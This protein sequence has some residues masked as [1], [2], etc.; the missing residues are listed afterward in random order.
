M[1]E[2]WN[3]FAEIVNTTADKHTPLATKRVCAESLPW[4][5]SEIRKM[6]WKR[7][8]HHK[9]AQKQKSTEGW[10]K[11][12]ELGNN[13]TCLIRNAKHDFYSTA[14]EENKKDSFKLCKALKTVTATNA[15]TSNI[16]SLETDNGIIQEPTEISQSFAQY[17]SS[18]IV[19]S[20]Q[21]TDSVLSASRSAIKYPSHISE[22][23]CI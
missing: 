22:S 11:Y 2:A 5:T 18:T 12:R 3:A 17:F 21:G 10:I 4:L 9:Q 15:K 1:H 20:R 8:F 19:T 13:T 16:E 23:Y 6:M 7:D 14:I